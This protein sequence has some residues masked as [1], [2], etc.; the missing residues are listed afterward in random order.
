[1]EI[2]EL[3]E[4]LAEAVR[5]FYPQAKKSKYHT[6]LGALSM[7]I[8]ASGEFAEVL[9]DFGFKET[10]R[11]SFMREYNFVPDTDI[12]RRRAKRDRDMELFPFDERQWRFHFV[13]K[14]EGFIIDWTARQFWASLPFPTIWRE[15]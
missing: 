2:D 1:M 7:C 14:V 8:D 13:N 11:R 6:P 9:S 12:D 3:P 10:K 5:A 15:P 4:K